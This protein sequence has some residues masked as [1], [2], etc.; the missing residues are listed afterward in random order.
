MISCVKC[1]NNRN[2]KLWIDLLSCSL[3][4]HNLSS[5]S[6]RRRVQMPVSRWGAVAV[7][8]APPVVARRN[9]RSLQHGQPQIIV[10]ICRRQASQSDL[11]IDIKALCPQHTSSNQHSVDMHY[12]WEARE[13]KARERENEWVCVRGTHKNMRNS[14]C[15][16]LT[17]CL[18][19]RER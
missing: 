7:S 9:K 5:F 12:E 3:L 13:K 17:C 19:V 11:T 10:D 6:R 16:Y 8:R 4:E 1:T 2:E 18:C 15:F 14:V